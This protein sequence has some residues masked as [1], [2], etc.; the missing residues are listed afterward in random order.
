MIRGRMALLALLAF[1]P[2]GGTSSTTT[3]Y[4]PAD[5]S[6]GAS[7]KTQVNMTFARAGK[8]LTA[9]FPSD[10]LRA[11][12]GK[13]DLSAFPNPQKLSII[14][15]LKGLIAEGHGFA[16]D[17]GVFFSLTGP[18]D[19]S[20]LPSL[21]ASVGAASTVF[22]MSVDATAPDYLERSPVTVYFTADGGPYGAPNMLSVV[23]LQGRPLRPGTT[24]AAVV[25]R[26]LGDVKGL[27]LEVSTSMSALAQGKTPAGMSSSAAAE[28][29]SAL[30]ALAKAHVKAADVAGLSV[31]TTDTELEQFQ[32]VK[33]AMLSL[34]LPKPT[35]AWTLTDTFPTYC[36]YQTTIG[37]PDY[38]GGTPP[39][40][41]TGGEWTFDAAGKPIVQRVEPSYLFATVP[42]TAMPKGGFP[43]SVFIRT[44]A[45]GNRPLVDRGRADSMTYSMGGAAVTPGTGPALYFAREGF[46]GLEVDGPLGGLRNTTKRVGSAKPIGWSSGTREFLGPNACHEPLGS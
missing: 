46:A 30:A 34:P 16:Q 9:P 20:A 5:A 6:T 22:L 41:A 1:D 13:V 36:V 10:D 44:G 29:T 28:Y 18:L 11:A 17:G 37:M 3:H 31:F 43:T 42:R 23:P 24:Y 25:L 33:D 40:D 15:Q 2:C 14:G 39:F 27:P 4:P 7:S 26:T 35:V 8:W 21:D 38:Q 19:K 12:D 32:K 45:G